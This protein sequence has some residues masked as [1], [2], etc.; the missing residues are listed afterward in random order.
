MYFICTFSDDPK[1]AN[2][3]S[4]LNANVI[5]DDT[6]QGATPA[7]RI[8]LEELA[9]SLDGK[10]KQRLYLACYILDYQHTTLFGRERTACFSG[11]GLDLP[12]P[13][14]QASWDAIYE[15]RAS[16]E[17]S[18]RRVWEV[19]D[20]GSLGEAG[21][22]SYDVFQSTLIMACLGD[23]LDCDSPGYAT[24]TGKGT[25]TIL[26]A[27][28]LSPRSKMAYHTFMLCK[29][30]PIRNLLAVAG[31][32]WVMAEKLS[33]PADYA[34]AQI[35]SRQ[36]AKGFADSRMDFT[37]MDM[38]GAHVDGAITHALRILELHMKH[39]RT[40]LLFQE[41]AIYIAS[42]VIWAKAY[43]TSNQTLLGARLAV[44]NPVQPQ[45]S[46][47]ELDSAMS[48][49]IAAGPNSN[50]DM[51]Q[52]RNVLLWTE[53]RIKNVDIPHNCGL[54]N[55]ALDVLGKLVMRGSEE[56]WFGS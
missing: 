1:L 27:M 33:R 12:F 51:N 37:T 8:Y 44:P 9:F 47:Y 15:S 42:I 45:I 11:S 50:I 3:I 54:T 46:P 32:S 23:G 6:M 39:P 24:I 18:H 26:S 25:S 2:D 22:Q 29:H 52:A 14:P 21:Q 48:A 17:S 28:E 43:V 35:A 36:W 38:E 41:W 4:V 40:G 31:E 49:V 56:G 7:A 20:G 30:T 10:C 55:G 53:A 16:D 34:A 5:S 19:L 13:Q